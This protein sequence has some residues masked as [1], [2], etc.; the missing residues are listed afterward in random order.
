V[1]DLFGIPGI[2]ASESF[3]SKISFILRLGIGGTFIWLACFEK[4]FNPHL[5]A[6]VVEHYSLT[7][8]IAVNSAMWTLSTGII[9]LIIGLMLLLGIH[10]R[11]AAVIAY[12]V[13]ISTFL[14]FGEHVSAHVTLFG[15]LAALF[16]LGNGNVSLETWY[17]KRKTT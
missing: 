3:T 6:Q 15:V 14:Y 2:P 17:A 10:T 5:F 4:I 16:I 13:L 12:S 11:V 8:M 1:D 7:N 9:E